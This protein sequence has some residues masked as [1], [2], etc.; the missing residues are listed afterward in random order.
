[1]F[2]NRRVSRGSLSPGPVVIARRVRLQAGGVMVVLAALATS[3]SLVL[4][5]AGGAPTPWLAAMVTLG[6]CLSAGGAVMTGLIGGHYPHARLG[7]C[8]VLTLTRGAG[9]AVLAGLLVVPEALTG[10]AALGWV[11]VVL[12][13]SVLVLDAADGWAARR[14]G[15]KSRFGARMD[16]E[17]D[18]AF[19]IV[20]AALAWQSGK[21]GVWFLAL[22][23]LRPAFLLAALVWP[24]LGAPLPDAMWRKTVAAVQ[25]TVQV[26]L[27]AP[28]VVPPVST[29][30]GAALLAGVVMSFAVDIRRL[31]V[32]APDASAGTQ[33]LPY[34][35]GHERGL[36]GRWQ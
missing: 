36:S 4:A 8:N 31:L 26:V 3:G 32:R 19:A 11:L 24:R 20:L 15:L 14:S 30:L 17:A 27:V 23:G 5:Q 25:M 2:Q 16:V 1:M 7:L 18:V 35:A 34:A 33:A 29:A 13:G 9:T 12:A 28:V 10:P 22:G 6:L 21:V